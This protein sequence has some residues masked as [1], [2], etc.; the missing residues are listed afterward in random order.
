[1]IAALL[2][3]VSLTVVAVR[4]PRIDPLLATRCVAYLAFDLAVGNMHADEFRLLLPLFPLVAVA[5]GVASARLAPPWR[6]R[7]WLGLTL[8]IVG[9]Y[10][11]LMLC[12]RFLRE[13]RGRRERSTITG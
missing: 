12:V 6:K 2:V 1:V 3:A 13:C 9:Q 4:S 11:W 10:A 5:C 7:A 8:G